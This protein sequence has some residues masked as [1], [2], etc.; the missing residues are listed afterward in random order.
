[1]VWL[2]PVPVATLGAIAWTS[3]TS[4]SRGPVEAVDSVQAYERFR[5]AMDAPIPPPRS[6]RSKIP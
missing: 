4:R 6:G 3:W 1:L 2:L 5:R